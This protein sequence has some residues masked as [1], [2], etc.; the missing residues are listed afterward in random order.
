VVGLAGHIDHGK[1]ALVEALTGVKGD[2]LKAERERGIT[3]D[4]G[5][6]V[7]S[8]TPDVAI[9]FID[10]PGHEDFIRNMAAGASGVEA[11]ILVISAAEGIMPQTREHLAIAWH[12]GCR[13][14]LLVVTKADLATDE[15]VQQ[16][17][18]EGQNLLAEWSIAP[19][20]S[21]AVSA[22][23]GRGLDDL[24][25]AL[26]AVLPASGDFDAPLRMPIDRAFQRTGIGTVVTGTLRSGQIALQQQVMLQPSGKCSRVRALHVH[27][28]E[29]A[30]A[31]AGQRVAV[32]LADIAR[33]DVS[34]GDVLVGEGTAEPVSA[35]DALVRFDR[36]LALSQL[37]Q[38]FVHIGTAALLARLVPLGQEGRQLGAGDHLMQ[39]RF[40]VPAS[41]LAGD[42]FVLRS[43]DARVTLGGGCI[44]TLDA[45]LR[46]RRQPERIQMLQL[47]AS[48]DVSELLEGLARLPPFALDLAALARAHGRSSAAL[49]EAAAK[50]ALIALPAGTGMA[51]IWHMHPAILLTLQRSILERLAAHHAA[52]PDQ[53]GMTPQ[54]L[55]SASPM[56]LLPDAFPALIRHLAIRGHL[57]QEGSFL[58]LPG[59][60]PQLSPQHAALWAEI[61][62]F[63]SDEN[64]LHPPKLAA[65]AEALG[66]RQDSLRGVFKRMARMG[67]VQEIA[68]D[69]YLQRDTVVELEI[70]LRKVAAEVETGWFTAAQFRDALGIGRKMAILVLE[71]F[72]RHGTTLRK[73]DLRRLNPLARN[74]AGG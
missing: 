29:V 71:S 62:P 59:Y 54:R 26:L 49:V 34:R 61:E 25:Q 35:C 13:R 50:D 65:I 39:L 20:A 15:I 68:E 38:V 44:L 14:I 19:E 74:Q 63:L 22:R 41:V 47:L 28:T 56:R 9:S 64:R 66:K 55:L 73:G 11:M 2:R 33:D 36:P 18:S 31:R 43:G 21:C 72:D 5:F 40:Q 60:K 17:L 70:V 1:T 52:Q 27:G 8:P 58:R 42:R 23:D 16:R 32:A 37:T 53:P 6:A 10:M 3:I 46:R 7:W 4:L 48:H 30:I 67:L 12:L 69:I 24:R 51:T 45:P 57:E